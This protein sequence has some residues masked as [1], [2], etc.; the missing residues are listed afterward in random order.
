MPTDPNRPR[1]VCY[2]TDANDALPSLWAHAKVE[3]LMQQDLRGVQRRNTSDDCKQQVTDFGVKYGLMTQF[4]SFVAVDSRYITSGGPAQRVEVP[5]E[6]PS[7]S[8][9]WCCGAAG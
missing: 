8:P 9:P 4:T 5:V 2:M 1:V 3:G 7:V 6:M